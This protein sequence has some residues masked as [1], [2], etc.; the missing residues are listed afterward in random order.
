MSASITRWV[1]QNIRG[2]LWPFGVPTTITKAMIKRA[3]FRAN[4]MR[5][6]G[7][8]AA[9]AGHMILPLERVAQMYK[10]DCETLAKLAR[11]ADALFDV[12]PGGAK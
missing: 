7:I 10:V 1:R 3:G 2:P 6:H 11:E 8:P 5:S 12:R 9:R 4:Y